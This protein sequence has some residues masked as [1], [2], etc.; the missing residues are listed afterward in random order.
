MIACR[1]PSVPSFW[2]FVTP[3]ATRPNFA[4]LSENDVSSL[5]DSSDWTNCSFGGV[6]CF[7]FFFFFL[8][9]NV[10]VAAEDGHISELPTETSSSR[11][12]SKCN[13]AF[14]GWEKAQTLRPAPAGREKGEDS[15]C[16][17]CQVYVKRMVTGQAVVL[18]KQ[19][20]ELVNRLEILECLREGICHSTRQEKPYL[21]DRKTE[22]GAQRLAQNHLGSY[23]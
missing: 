10:Q 8:I 18:E 7:A 20:E 5:V 23:R 3:T 2:V 11:A 15:L 9:Y 1:C 19:R 4:K 17:G 6:G 14:A 16:H 22:A 21:T 13:R 12:R